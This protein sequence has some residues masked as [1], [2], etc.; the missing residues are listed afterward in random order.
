[1]VGTCG[2][3]SLQFSWLDASVLCGVFVSKQQKYRSTGLEKLNVPGQP[4]NNLKGLIVPVKSRNN[5]DKII[6][7]V[8]QSLAV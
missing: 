6:G 5:R 4:E 7:F 1:L 3:G 8:R 2:V